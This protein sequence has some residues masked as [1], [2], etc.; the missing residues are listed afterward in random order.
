MV[1]SYLYA[2]TACMK[3]LQEKWNR[4]AQIVGFDSN[5]AQATFSL[6]DSLY[7][8]PQRKYHTWAHITTV[9]TLAQ[10]FKQSIQDPIS[11]EA[12]IWFHDAI[13]VPY[14]HDNE[15]NSAYLADCVLRTSRLQD[16]QIRNCI[17]III[18]TEYTQMR[19][20]DRGD[21]ALFHDLDFAIF[22]F[23]LEQVL[24]YDNNIHDE[25]LCATQITET[26]FFVQRK[27]FLTNLL[28][29]QELFKAVESKK[30]WEQQA[31]E[32]ITYLLAK[33]YQ[34]MSPVPV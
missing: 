10:Q 32:N 3:Q 1:S 31:R 12:A 26:E 33:R 22:A 20:P 15:K 8:E 2:Y 9:L 27:L 13:Y 4:F 14:R 23:P 17:E 21:S 6:L 24:A 30:T 7:S 5:S 11:F 16:E 34:R 28:H 19:K 18:S 25:F 29:K